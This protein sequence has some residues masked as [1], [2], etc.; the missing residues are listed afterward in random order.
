MPNL[1]NG[2]LGAGIHLRQHDG[3]MSQRKT[4][5]AAPSFFDLSALLELIPH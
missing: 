2:A 4:T 3:P 5:P 1:L